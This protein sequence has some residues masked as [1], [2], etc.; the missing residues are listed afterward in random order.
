MGLY[1]RMG[2]DETTA[3]KDKAHRMIEAR[4]D[5]VPFV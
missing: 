5:C 3:L 1:M 2:S 4:G